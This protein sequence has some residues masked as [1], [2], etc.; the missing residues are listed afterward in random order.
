MLCG[1][2]RYG[3]PQRQKRSG[4][5]VSH[6]KITGRG[7]SCPLL[8]ETFTSFLGVFMVPNVRHG[9]MSVSCF[10]LADKPLYTSAI[11]RILGTW[12]VGDS[13][14]DAAVTAGG[15]TDA[16]GVGA[17]TFTFSQMG[18]HFRLHKQTLQSFRQRGQ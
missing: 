9:M 2:Q 8:L 3:E 5:P 15:V 6:Y 17:A 11:E 10:S 13:G 4:V 1:W 14:N 18:R 12:L 16:A 7:I